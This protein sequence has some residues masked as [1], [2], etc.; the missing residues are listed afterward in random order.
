M[1]DLAEVIR[2]VADDPTEI[3]AA[4][5]V[6]EALRRVAPGRVWDALVMKGA[7]AACGD[8]GTSPLRLVRRLLSAALTDR[9]LALGPSHPE[10]R[11]VVGARAQELAE[12]G[13]LEQAHALAVQVTGTALD[14]LRLGML[15][16]ATGRGTERLEALGAGDD[17]I[18][19]EACVQ[20]AVHHFGGGRGRAGLDALRRAMARPEPHTFFRQPLPLLPDAGSDPAAKIVGELASCLRWNGLAGAPSTASALLRL[21]PV[22]ADPDVGR[23][24]RDEVLSWVDADAGEVDAEGTPFA[25]ELADHLAA[26]GAQA[27]AAEVLA[28]ARPARVKLA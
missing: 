3:A 13:D 26:A 14:A 9:V 8:R 7:E 1:E 6:D 12:S 21:A 5:A 19:W 20:L 10:F 11:P 17:G 24:L 22:L 25:V 18:A 16:A 23:A 4:T 27:D 28:R 2:A 15:E